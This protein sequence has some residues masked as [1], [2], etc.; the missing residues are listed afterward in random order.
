MTNGDNL[1]MQNVVDRV[2]D[3]VSKNPPPDTISL[4][5]AGLNYVN[6]VWQDKMVNGM[7]ISLLGGITAVFIMMALLFRSFLWAVLF[8]V[9]LATT[10]T[11]IYAL[12]GF[13][14]KAYDMPVAVLSS[15]TLGLSI[16]FAIHFIRRAQMIH[17]NTNDFSETMN[18]VFEEPAKAIAINMVIVAFGF[19]PLLGSSLVPYI[20]VGSFLFLIMITSG[21]ATLIMLPA[22]SKVMQKRLFPQ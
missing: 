22:L 12:I 17:K 21:I 16:D 8:M 6:V 4:T 11:G 14:G 3:Y 18:Q 13:T 1:T 19:L 7:V 10:I 15:L 5:W 20:T 9:P 2:E